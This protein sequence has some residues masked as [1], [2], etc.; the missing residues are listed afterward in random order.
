MWCKRSSSLQF[1]CYK[2]PMNWFIN[3]SAA[4]RGNEEKAYV[5]V[6]FANVF[7][8][9]QMLQSNRC[10]RASERPF[11]LTPA[12]IYA[13][14]INRSFAFPFFRYHSTRTHWMKFDYALLFVQFPAA[15]PLIILLFNILDLYYNFIYTNM[16]VYALLI[17]HI[18]IR[19]NMCKFRLCYCLY[20]AKCG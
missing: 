16:C 1:K 12:H 8:F 19:A 15:L 9:L 10:P 7:F 13:Y 18:R 3:P 6:Y 20:Q 2:W 5:S 14:R 11:I 17:S 4:C